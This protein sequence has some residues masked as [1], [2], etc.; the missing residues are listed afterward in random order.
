MKDHP[1]TKIIQLFRDILRD[2]IKTKENDIEESL[3]FMQEK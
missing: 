3:S 1:I 2:F